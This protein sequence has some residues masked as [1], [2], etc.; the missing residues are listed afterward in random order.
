MMLQFLLAFLLGSA[1]QL[2]SNS[3]VCLTYCK[4]G[5]L[6]PPLSLALFPSS[7]SVPSFP[8]SLPP[9]LSLHGQS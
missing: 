1:S 3:S 6:P 2:P 9:L 4:R 8:I 7:L 5:F